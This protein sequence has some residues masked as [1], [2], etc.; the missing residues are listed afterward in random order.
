MAS[1]FVLNVGQ[2]Q[3][4]LSKD[5]VNFPLAYCLASSRE[6]TSSRLKTISVASSLFK[7]HKKAR[8]TFDIQSNQGYFQL[9]PRKQPNWTF[10]LTLNI[11][12]Y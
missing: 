7:D 10:Q 8:S 12:L 3:A 2:I 6:P 4:Y 1:K 5:I 9:G 11:I